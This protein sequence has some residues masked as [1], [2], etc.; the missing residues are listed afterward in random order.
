MNKQ[1]KL[2]SLLVIAIGLTFSA[3][4]KDENAPAITLTSLK[5]GATDLNGATS[6][7][8]VST[9]ENIVAVFST[10]VDATTAN[11]TNIKLMNGSTAVA[12]TLTVTGST[13]TIDPTDNLLT[14]G[15]Y[16]LS[17]SGVKSDQGQALATV[18]V[19]FTTQGVGLE[20]PPQKASQ[21]MYLQF[22]NSIV[23][24]TGNA[25]VGFEQV[26]YTTDRFGNANA[27]AF[28]AGQDVP[29]TGDI[30]ELDG[31]NFIN[32]S[33]TISVWF[34]LDPAT[35]GPGSREMFGICA[36]YGYFME[37]AGDLAWMKLPTSHKV[38]PSGIPPHNFGT[39][40]TD[41]ING[42]SPVGGMLLYN[43]LGSIST[44]IGGNTWHQL[45]LTYDASSSLKTVF[46]DGVKIMQA[47]ID[48]GQTEWILK[49]LALATDD[50]GTPIVGLD[51]KLAI[52]FSSSRA[53]TA[54]SWS[55]YLTQAN[56][57]KG[58]LDDMRIWNKALT[59]GEV[60][61]LYTIE[62]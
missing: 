30:V 37:V 18:S 24:L 56:T 39:A 38:D 14:G 47:D 15:L 9:T 59:E 11:G 25:T 51:A 45:A 5:S 13:V 50:G 23:D 1:I 60:A 27:A 57:F 44:L 58:A 16:T 41:Y 53:N 43:Y 2:L 7:T 32:P 22:D 31:T 34:K 49:D 46:I 29:G 42:G 6:A 4:K 17:I 35:F 19:T 62:Q 26:T 3:C 61:T 10:T 54:T 33:T 28:F 20:T 55:N 21:V 12:I 48:L 40:W 52:G 36:Q 8:D